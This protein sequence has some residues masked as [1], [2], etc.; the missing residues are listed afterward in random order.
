MEIIII[1]YEKKQPGLHIQRQ[2]HI[3]KKFPDWMLSSIATGNRCDLSELRKV[4]VF[5]CFYGQEHL[6][7]MADYGGPPL[8]YSDWFPST[9]AHTRSFF[10][11]LLFPYY[12]TWLRT[13][14]IPSHTTWLF[15]LHGGIIQK[16]TLLEQFMRQTKRLGPNHNWWQNQNEKS[17]SLIPRFPT[18]IRLHSASLLWVNMTNF[19]RDQQAGIY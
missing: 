5:F 14:Q 12:S 10:L 1:R 9:S 13:P 3:Q 7:M 6:I 8:P 15:G 17:S 4:E 2:L 11:L 19:P 16:T 18:S